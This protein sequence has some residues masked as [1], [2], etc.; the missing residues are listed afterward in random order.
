VIGK[1]DVSY[2]DLPALLPADDKCDNAVTR[3]LLGIACCLLE[4]VCTTQFEVNAYS[5]YLLLGAA[6]RCLGAAVCCIVKFTACVIVGRCLP[7]ARGCVRR[8]QQTGMIVVLLNVACCLPYAAC[9]MCI[10]VTPCCRRYT[11]AISLCVYHLACCWEGAW[12]GCS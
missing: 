5:I 11:P 4:A 7:I 10:V 1:R 8:M 9:L 12:W 6:G 3:L 2:T